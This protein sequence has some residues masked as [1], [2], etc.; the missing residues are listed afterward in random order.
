[1]SP[2]D[3]NIARKGRILRDHH[4]AQP[5]AA[6]DVPSFSL[7]EF[8]LSELCNRRCPFCPRSDPKVYP[9][10]KLFM[11]DALYSKI[12]KD[13][14]S[15]GYSGKI[16]YSAFS[17]PLLHKSVEEFIRV[18][19]ERCPRARVE[20]VTDGDFVTV[21]KLI[22]LFGAGLDTLLISMYDG[23]HQEGQFRALCDEA[24]LSEKQVILRKRYLPP[25]EDYGIVLSNRAGMVHLPRNGIGPLAE[26]IRER[27]FYPFYQ[28]MVD[29]D[30][31][32]LL[33]PHDWS[34]QLRA[35]NLN[36]QSVL[37][38][39]T[40]HPL[41]QARVRLGA[42]DRGFSP[43]NGCNVKGTLMGGEH[44]ERW[45]SSLT[46]VLQPPSGAGET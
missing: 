29:W 40:S 16:L 31:T 32:V 39:W 44:F 46:K 34:K 5:F 33:C 24:G 6:D 11:S 15:F 23:P 41:M 26:P 17:E 7:I 8:N 25:E 2:I 9:N 18:S 37:E 10:R 19:K 28:M 13:L 30:G 4:Q 45:Q 1:M 3:P 20:I 12:M 35:G 14:A 22:A 38:L 27:C 36:E 43:C 21:P 42:A